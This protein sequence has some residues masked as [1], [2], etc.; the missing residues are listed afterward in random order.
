VVYSSF[1]G[2]SVP[3][4]GLLYEVQGNALCG[5]NFRYSIRPAI[6]PS[7]PRPSICD[8]VSVRQFFTKFGYQNSYKNL[9]NKDHFRE[10]RPSNND[11]LNV[12][13]YVFSH[14]LPISSKDFLKFG[15]LRN[16]VAYL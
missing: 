1:Y 14:K 5:G 7:S 3:I 13:L 9:F 15:T 2:T 11:S 16:A 10:N 6:H 4:F 12:G 8:L